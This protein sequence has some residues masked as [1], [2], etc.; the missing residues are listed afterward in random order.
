MQLSIIIRVN[1]FVCRVYETN[2][3]FVLGKTDIIGSLI[4]ISHFGIVAAENFSLF[5]TLHLTKIGTV[6]FLVRYLEYEN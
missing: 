6:V 1:D 4:G 2:L 5:L 3:Q